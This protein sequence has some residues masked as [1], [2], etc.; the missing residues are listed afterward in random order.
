[1]TV[2]FTSEFDGKLDLLDNN[3][4]GHQF[5]VP[6]SIVDKYS[7]GNWVVTTVDPLVHR[8]DFVSARVKA[9][10]KVRL[11]TTIS[12]YFKGKAGPMTEYEWDGTKWNSSVVLDTKS[13]ATAMIKEGMARNDDTMRLYAPYYVNGTIHELTWAEPWVDNTS[14]VSI[15]QKIDPSN[16]VR[17]TILP[18]PVTNN[19]LELR[20]ENL[21]SPQIELQ[22][23]SLDGKMILERSLEHI[24]LNSHKIIDVSS[25][26]NGQYIVTLFNEGISLRSNLSIQR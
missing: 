2:K 25:L 9:D 17:W 24:D 26:S 7:D 18:N 5:K 12:E 10:G 19:S 6:Q 14:H 4:Y 1:M 8:G 11:Y 22:I 21:I 23:N 15:P 3:V 16:E 20:F 13:G